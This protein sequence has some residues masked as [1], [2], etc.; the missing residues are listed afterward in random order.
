MKFI[1]QTTLFCATLA[2]ATPAPLAGP[3]VPKTI[4]EFRQALTAR[5]AAA[6]PQLDERSSKPKGSSG[7][8]SS[9][10][11]SV[12]ISVS[13]SGALMVGALGLGILEVALWN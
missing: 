6:L 13:P 7:G 10:N 1:A 3:A 11:S 12:A 2:L 4:A 5:A 8:S 9:S